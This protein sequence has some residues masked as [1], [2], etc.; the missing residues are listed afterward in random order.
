[1]TEPL[2]TDLLAEL[3]DAKRDVLEQ[4]RQLVRQQ[5]DLVA[6]G[7]LARLMSVLAA[8]ESVLRSLL[9]I[10]RQLDP[11]RPEDPDSRR[12]RSAEA[13]ARCQQVVERSQALLAE[14]MLLEK[15][16]ETELRQR[17]DDTA[18]RLDAA[19]VALEAHRAYSGHTEAARSQLD[20][21][22]EG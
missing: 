16:G 6:M 4:L 1:M 14:I 13:R 17:R 8:K 7:D 11:F 2:P 21:T 19:H 18:A 10:E 20:V 12:W 15:Q 3:I 9:H 5:N 22:S